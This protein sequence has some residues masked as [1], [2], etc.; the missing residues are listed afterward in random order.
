MTVFC[1]TGQ[2]IYIWYVQ[3]PSLQLQEVIVAQGFEGPIHMNLSQAT[4][5]RDQFLGQGQIHCLDPFWIP[6]AQSQPVEEIQQ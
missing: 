6:L 3:L 1:L 4:D 2:Q 5:I